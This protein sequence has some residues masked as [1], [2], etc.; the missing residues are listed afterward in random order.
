MPKSGAAGRVLAVKENT[1]YGWIF[2][3]Q[4]RDG[5][6]AVNFA[7]LRAQAR[8]LAAS[9]PGTQVSELAGIVEKL[10][11]EC[12]KLE[13]AVIDAQAEAHRAKLNSK[14]G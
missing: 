3:Q 14:K 6:G 7:Y 11:A 12:E 9:N 2:D 8:A 5:G 10:C 1:E 4:K 13:K